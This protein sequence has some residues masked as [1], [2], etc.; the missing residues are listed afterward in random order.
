MIRRNFIFILLFCICLV[1]VYQYLSKSSRVSYKYQETKDLVSFVRRAS[2][3][4]EKK[5]EA[6]FEEL[7]KKPWFDNERYVFVDTLDGVEVL[8][9]AF[10]KLEGTNL[11]NIK[12]SWGKM[13]VKNYIREVSA[14]GKKSEGWTHYLWPKP[15]SKKESWKTTY[16]KLVKAPSGEKYVVGSGAYDMK[17]EPSFAVDEVK[18]ACKL[19]REKGEDA[20]DIIRAMSRE[21]YFKDTYVFVG[22]LDGVELVNPK[23]PSLRSKNIWDLKDVNGKLLVQEYISLAKAKGSGWVAYMW[24]KKEGGKPTEKT[25]L[26]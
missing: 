9:P 5:G 23:F 4:I 8:N 13:L 3:L 22:R 18:D 17:M 1:F 19:I 25:Y 12:D 26:R 15:G 16:L 20:F 24:P 14:Y 2:S 10:P 21:F 7:R 6:A 11:M